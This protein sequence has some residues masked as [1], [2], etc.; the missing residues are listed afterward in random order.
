[1][2]TYSGSRPTEKVTINL[3]EGKMNIGMCIVCKPYQ[4]DLCFKQLFASQ[5]SMAEFRLS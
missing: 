1:M 5:T 2:L 3:E 4:S